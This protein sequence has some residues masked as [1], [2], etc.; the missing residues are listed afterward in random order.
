MEITFYTIEQKI[1]IAFDTVSTVEYT[2][3]PSLYRIRIEPP[4]SYT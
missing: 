3:H 1:P 4:N 2:N